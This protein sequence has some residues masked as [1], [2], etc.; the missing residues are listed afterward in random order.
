MQGLASAEA[1]AAAANKE[2][3]QAATMLLHSK[4]EVESTERD[5]HLVLIVRR[6]AEEVQ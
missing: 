1:E 5:E 4:S 3:Q 2:L 6:T